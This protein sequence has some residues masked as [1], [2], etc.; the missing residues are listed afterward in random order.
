MIKKGIILAGGHGTR[1]SP[2]T[3]A[4]NKQLLPIYD[5]PLIYYPLSTLML[6]GI[7]DILII[8]TPKDLQLFQQL[9]N[10]GSG[11]GVNIQYA[12]QASPNGIAEALIIAK[13]FI[14]KSNVAL[15][16]G[17]NI[18]YGHN[19]SNVLASAAGRNEGAT[20]FAYH[21]NDPERYGVVAFDDQKKV[22]GIEEKPESPQS[23][24]AVTGLYYYDNDSVKYAEAIKPSSRGELE[25][26]DL[27]NCYLDANL[28]Y[29]E[30]MGRG[31]A[32]FDAGTHKSMLEASQFI[33]GIEARG[34]QKICCPEEIA[35]SQN[36]IDASAL[37]E[38]AKRL[39]NSPYGEYLISLIKD[40][41]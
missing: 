7:R 32:W 20:I 27:N 40:T 10:D 36:W 37:E 35:Y 5:K 2:L 25:I 16:L 19:F 6:S 24:Y 23:N 34:G 3:K 9:L 17:D 38:H 8:T 30:V 28:L 22:T 14:D 15:I 1:M 11:W 31:F 26:T 12:V 33:A 39:S 21:V 18:F 41:F 29:V 13:P 4:V